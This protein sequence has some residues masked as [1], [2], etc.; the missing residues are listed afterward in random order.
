VNLTND[1]SQIDVDN[2]VPHGEWTI[3]KT[4]IFSTNK[5]GDCATRCLLTH[6]HRIAQDG[7]TV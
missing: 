5:V 4:R 3:I 7:S 1:H 2:Y 6:V